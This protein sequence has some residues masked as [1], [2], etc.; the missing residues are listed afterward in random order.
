MVVHH[1]VDGGDDCDQNKLTTSQTS[2]IAHLQSEKSLQ[3]SIPDSK[4]HL[5]V[6]A[7][8]PI[9]DSPNTIIVNKP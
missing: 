2:S 7:K 1:G 4:M 6:A 9:I 3:D 8:H 5:E